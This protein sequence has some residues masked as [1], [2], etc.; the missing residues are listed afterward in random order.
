MYCTG[1]S[2]PDRTVIAVVGG[3]ASGTLATLHLLRRAT[4]ERA[5]LHIALIDQHGRHGLGDAYATRHP[6]HLLNAPATIMSAVTGDP[7][8]LT[9]WASAEGLGHEE[10]LPRPEYGRYL[11]ETLAQAERQAL[12]G[13]R[14]SHIT[15]Q[16]VAIRRSTSGRPLRLHLAADGRLDADVVILATGSQPPATP[17][18][19]PDSPRY[20]ADP[21]EP[22]ALDGLADGSPVVVVGTGLTML[23]VAVSATA[24][25]PR[26]VVDAVSRHAL[27]PLSHRL[28]PQFGGTC[29]VPALDDPDSPLRLAALIWQVRAA[30]ADSPGHWQQVVD[31]LRPHIPSLWQRLSLADQRV[32]LTHVARYWEIHRHRM[33]PATAQRVTMLRATG[34]L[35]VNRGRVTVAE[36]DP[37]GLRVTITCERSSRTL[38]AGWLVNATG[39]G[40]DVSRS[41]DPLWQDLF[42]T[43]LARPDALRLGIDAGEDG[44]VRDAHGIPARDVFTLGPTLRG[45]RYETTA[46]PEIRDQAD[47]LARR[48]SGPIAIGARHGS[49]A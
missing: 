5:P 20:I 1:D 15:S 40:T 26:T 49:A 46:V 39:P 16:V 18:P 13:T 41:P 44:A 34:R 22:G 4:P 37:A 24:G 7:S 14:V 2:D 21:W 3:G 10:F 17:F 9:R 11:R 8:H 30:V 38:T 28:T 48:L 31:A 42:K 45:T 43:G 33:P 35:R 6:G 25:S 23:D 36:P 29:W 47:A 32:F 27:L 19:V 12:P